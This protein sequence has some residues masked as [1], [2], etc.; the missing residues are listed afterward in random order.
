MHLY[1]SFFFA[2]ILF[3]M[4][5]TQTSLG[6]KIYYDILIPLQ[7]YFVDSN[8]FLPQQVVCSSPPRLF[9]LLIY[10]CNFSSCCFSF[11][12]FFFFPLLYLQVFK[13]GEG[14]ALS[15]K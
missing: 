5:K 2:A 14:E 6:R 3:H 12:I 4:Q 15:L 8:R 10:C 9:F 1:L 7:N 13:S 11:L